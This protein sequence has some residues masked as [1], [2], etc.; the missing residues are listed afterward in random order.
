V[1][2]IA[3]PFLVFDQAAVNASPWALV[4]IDGTMADLGDYIEGWDYARDLHVQRSFELG[5]LDVNA[6]GIE[7]E[8]LDL[9]VVVRLGTGP[10]SMSRRSRTLSSQALQF[11]LPLILDHRIP[12][13]ELS[14]RLRLET[15]V[16]LRSHGDPASRLAPKMPG[17]ILWRDHVDVALEGEAPRFPMEIISFGER[18]PD[19][20]E[21]GAPWLLHW[22]PGHLHRDFGGSVRLFLNHDRP[23]FIERFVAADPL[24][25]QMTLAGVISQILGH[26]VRQDDLGEILDDADPTSVAGHIGIWMQL[27]FP[28][29]DLAGVRSVHEM[30]PGRFQAAILAMADPRILDTSK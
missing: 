12:G 23:E 1:K 8:D 7:P 11:G 4:G 2:Y 25:L 19:R 20:S 27:A 5:E 29:L 17:S 6:L 24:T 26:A 18:F 16:I 10:G 13:M 28:D 15:T 3:F 9:Q 22:L 14:R 21:R 30:A